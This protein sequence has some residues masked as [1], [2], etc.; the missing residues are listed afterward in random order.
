MEQPKMPKNLLEPYKVKTLKDLES[1][2]ILRF[3]KTDEKMIIKDILVAI[4][5]DGSREPNFMFTGMAVKR[6]LINK[7]FETSSEGHLKVY[8]N[9]S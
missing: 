8:F 3:N 4:E 2:D 7:M 6:R 5:E 1:G 9:I